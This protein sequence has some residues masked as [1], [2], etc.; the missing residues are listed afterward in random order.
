MLAT[1]IQTGSMEGRVVHGS[2]TKLF[3]CVHSPAASRGL[4]LAQLNSVA[5]KQ[6][7]DN[8]VMPLISAMLD[9]L[10]SMRTVL[11]LLQNLQQCHLF[12][13]VMVPLPWEGEHDRCIYYVCTHVLHYHAMNTFSSAFRVLIPGSRSILTA[14][15]EEPDL[16][17]T[18][19][20]TSLLALYVV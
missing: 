17:K 12:A 4:G 13:L 6:F 18:C 19:A 16:L 1:L 20:E 8:V 9:E 14:Y 7:H 2:L 15:C 11:Q 5:A 10:A 3:D